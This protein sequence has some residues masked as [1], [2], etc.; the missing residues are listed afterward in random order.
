MK[1]LQYFPF[2]RNQY[3][4]GKLITQQDFVSEQQYM[5][6]KRRLINRFLHGVGVAAGLQVVRLDDRSFS[7]EAGLALDE[8]GRE[9]LVDKPIV[10]RLDRLAGY[11]EL[12]DSTSADMVYLCISYSEEEVYP[13]RSMAKNDNSREQVYEKCREGFRLWLTGKPFEEDGNT[14]ESFIEK[15]TTLFENADLLITQHIPAFAQAGEQLETR[16]RITAKHPVQNAEVSFEE[17]LSCLL[18]GGEDRLCGSW[19]GSLRNQGEFAEQSYLMQAYSIEQGTGEMIL[20]PYKL[21]VNIGDQV[22][23]TRTEVRAEIRINSRDVRDELKDTWYENAM[24]QVLAGNYPGGIYLAAI[25]LKSS[26]REYLIDRIE[27]LPFDQRV[28]NPFLNMSMSDLLGREIRHLGTKL[29]TDTARE[30]AN[31]E[32]SARQKEIVSGVA[33]ISMG[34]GGKAGERFYSGEIIHGLGLG[35]IDIRTSIEE[36]LYQYSG[37]PEIFEDMGIRAETAV[38]VNREKGSFVIGIRL[39][40]ASAVKEVRVHWIAEKVPETFE[41]DREAHIRILPDKP[42]LKVMQNRYFRVQTENL[43]GMTILWEV[44]TPNGGVIT[45]DGHYTAP[46]TAGIYEVAAFCQE[47]PKI[48]NSV[49][50]IVRE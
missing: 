7:L 23:H 42:E 22:L 50:V 18:C 25:Y 10:Q 1:N 37:S 47:M 40:E 35:V 49:F 29:S 27:P 17:N 28:Y 20:A 34:I 44:T 12:M 38:R 30:P 32:R 39:L 14:L 21:T 33:S 9:I 24:N 41:A 4:Y 19:K 11:E 45:R 48:R 46:D 2:E 26:G 3:Y 15:K 16:I 31:E 43:E 36:N 5:N 13:S 8:T 6:D